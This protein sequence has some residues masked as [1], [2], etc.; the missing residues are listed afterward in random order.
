M[1]FSLEAP[2]AACIRWIFRHALKFLVVCCLLTLIAAGSALAQ[3][4]YGS[5]VKV[6]PFTQPGSVNEMAILDMNG[7][8]LDDIL[9]ASL[10][11]PLQNLGIPIQILLNDGNGGFFDGT[12]QVINGPVPSTVHPRKVVVADF[13]GDGKLDVFIADHGYDVDPF[14]GAQN[15]LLLSTPDGRYVDAT[16][17]LPQRLDFTHSGSAADIDGSGR[18]A[19]Y[20]GNIYGQQN[21]GP[22]LLLN[23]GT[24]HFTI[25]SG[26]L[27]PAQTNLNQ[28]VYSSS[29]F[30]DVDGDRCSDLVLGG[31]FNTQSVVLINDCTGHFSVL[32]NALLPKLFADGNTIDIKAMKLGSTGKP[33]LLLVSTHQTPF[34]V[35]RAVQV[36]INNGDGTF[37]DESAQ[38]LGLQE[39]TGN[40]L[41]YVWPTDLTGDCNLDFFMAATTAMR[42]GFTSMTV[43]GISRG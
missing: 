41:V 17:N 4:Q 12:A 37:H 13:N 42:G 34:Y 24:G 18:V 21:I 7:D 32:P 33:D 3:T 15:T 20:A 43:Q 10:Y 2:S 38:R 19:I 5:P 11:F 35:G 36:L 30:V 39:D 25:S 6:A 16:A 40:W 8:G 1:M 27:P 14:P 26:R 22:S 29:Q 9:A 31:D 23:D 28:N